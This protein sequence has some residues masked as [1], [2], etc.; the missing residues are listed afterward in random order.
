MATPQRDLCDPSAVFLEWGDVLNY[1]KAPKASRGCP[2]KGHSPGAREM[3]PPPSQL[4]RP[5]GRAPPEDGSRGVLP[6]PAGFCGSRVLG[7]W[8]W[9]PPLPL[10]RVSQLQRL[11]TSRPA[12]LTVALGGANFP[13]PARLTAP[14]WL[15]L[16]TPILMVCPQLLPE[17]LVKPQA[18]LML[19][20]WS[21]ALIS[22]NGAPASP[23]T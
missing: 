2:H 4:R 23:V 19:H 16:L 18:H 3:P 14:L 9:P 17:C 22:F 8:P 6:A 12:L 13:F 15:N 10:P 7:L 1:P 5:E 11:R 20:L 21:V